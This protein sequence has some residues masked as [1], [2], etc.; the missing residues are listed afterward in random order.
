MSEEPESKPNATTTTGA[1]GREMPKLT[2]N[3][4]LLLFLFLMIRENK[5]WWLLPLLFVL[6]ILSMFVSLTGNASILPA[7]YALF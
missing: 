3:R 6:S 2:S 4:E 5:K 1:E 7:I